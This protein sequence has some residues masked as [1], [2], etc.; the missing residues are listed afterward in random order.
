MEGFV[1]YLKP[2]SMHP[3]HV[4][5]GSV[6]AESMKSGAVVHESGIPIIFPLDLISLEAVVNNINWEKYRV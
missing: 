6:S 3:K 1:S 2:L 4:H 5:N